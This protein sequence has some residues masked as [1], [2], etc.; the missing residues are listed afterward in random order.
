LDVDRGLY[1][2]KDLT[3][4]HVRILK[5]IGYMLT[6]QTL[7]Q[8]RGE[9]YLIRLD[10]PQYQE[11]LE[12]QFFVKYTEQLVRRYTDKIELYRTRKPDI[13]FEDRFGKKIAVE[14]ETGT[15]LTN[16]GKLEEKAALLK[17]NY[18]DNYF[19]LVIDRLKRKQYAHYGEAIT[20][21][22]LERKIRG[23]F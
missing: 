11:S 9:Y 18:G 1:R 13:V 7:G 22:N 8:G 6:R 4:G 17:Q 15:T 19:F 20:R 12:H 21:M 3:E 5:D 23:Y 10:A 14:V 2:V 16:R